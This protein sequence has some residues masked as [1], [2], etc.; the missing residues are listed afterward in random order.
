[1]QLYA[2]E[3]KQRFGALSI[4]EKNLLL[5]GLMKMMKERKVTWQ[6]VVWK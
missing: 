6:L 2:E 1:M 5:G 3:V 4:V